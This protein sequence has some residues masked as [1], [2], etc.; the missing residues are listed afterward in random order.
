MGV[1]ALVGIGMMLIALAIREFADFALAF[2]HSAVN[3]TTLGYGDI[4]MSPRWRL[5]GPQEAA[6]G[7][8]AFGRSTAVVVTV[9]IRLFRYRQTRPAQTERP[10]SLIESRSRRT[11]VSPLPASATRPGARNPGSARKFRRAC[12]EDRQMPNHGTRIVH[13]NV[14]DSVTWRWHLACD[15]ERKAAMGR[16]NHTVLVLNAGCCL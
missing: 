7:T 9:V 4:V 1:A 14:I 16:Y 5:L 12:A 15:Y 11:G 8:L 6:S 10:P 2:D 3:Y 13:L